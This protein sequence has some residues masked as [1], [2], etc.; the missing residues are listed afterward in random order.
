MKNSFKTLL[1]TFLLVSTSNYAQE[2]CIPFHISPNGKDI[3]LEGYE[4]KGEKLDLLYDSG[5]MGNLLSRSAAEQMGFALSQDSSRFKILDGRK[6]TSYYFT[7]FYIDPFWDLFVSA[8]S[9]SAMKELAGEGVDG[10]VGF[11]RALDKY[12]LELD[13]ENSRLCFWNS[14]PDFYATDKR[15]MSIP[16]VRSDYEAEIEESRYLARNVFSIKGTVS[17]ADSVVNTTFILDSGCQRY[18]LYHYFDE[19]LFNK[20][21][22]YKKEITEKYGNDRPTTKL[23]IPELGIDSL[24]TSIP[25]TPMF[26]RN[27]LHGLCFGRRPIGC[28]LGVYFFRQYKKILFDWRNKMAY[29]YKGD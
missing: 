13:F 11:T 12:M 14:I 26:D 24:M 29:F 28:Y 25:S 6:F 20:A 27:D 10:L 7:S 18:L 4:M 9:D 1:I 17:I 8:T 3:I 5:T 21:I 23:S 19:N 15:V 16:L 2:F 22:N